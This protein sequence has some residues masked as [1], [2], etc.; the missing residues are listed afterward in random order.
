M[1]VF[2]LYV[3]VSPRRPSASWLPAFSGRRHVVI[4]SGGMRCFAVVDD[5]NICSML[6]MPLIDKLFSHRSS[7]GKSGSQSGASSVSSFLDSHGNHSADYFESR[8]RADCI[9]VTSGKLLTAHRAVLAQRSPELRDMIIMETPTVYNHNGDDVMS[10]GSESGVQ[11]LIQILLP[12]LHIDAARALLHFLYCD[13]LPIE[14]VGN[15]SLLQ[16]LVRAGKSLRIPRLQVLSEHLI[17]VLMDMEITTS[18][19][20]DNNSAD[21]SH[22]KA[23]VSMTLELPPVTL[24]RD[25]GSLVGDPQFADV[26]FVAEGRAIYAHKFI[27]ECRSEYFRAMFRSGMAESRRHNHGGEF[28]DSIDVVVPGLLVYLSISFK[29]FLS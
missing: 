1:I 21:I 11:S 8:G 4:A 23:S 19:S 5:E 26:R 17:Q 24:S 14:C 18:T 2:L 6:S 12:E 15:V 7:K 9:I 27:L 29:C 28:G 22:A 25:L 3:F 16:A 10:V 13:V 20:S